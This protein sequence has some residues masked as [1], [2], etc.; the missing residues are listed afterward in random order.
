[1]TMAH[2]PTS[3]EPA[4]EGK[5]LSGGFFVLRISGSGYTHKSKLHV[6]SFSYSGGSYVYDTPPAGLFSDAGPDVTAGEYMALLAPLFLTGWTIAFESLWRM[7]SGEPQQQF[8]TPVVASVSGTATQAAGVQYTP[9]GQ[10]TLTSRDTAGKPFRVTALGLSS[11]A[12]LAPSTIADNGSGNAWEKLVHFLVNDGAVR[13]HAGNKPLAPMKQQ[14]ALN[15]RLRREYH[16][17]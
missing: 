5:D 15:R 4:T 1:M 3:P 10:M 17:T 9:A 12:P 6:A 7:V 8:P 2:G 16:L 13:S 11:W 14:W